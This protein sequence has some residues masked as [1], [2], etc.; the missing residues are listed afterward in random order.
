MMAKA[1]AILVFI[2][3]FLL[4]PRAQA[5]F[6]SKKAKTII[7]E[8]M[9][10]EP[11]TYELH[12]LTAKQSMLERVRTFFSF[13]K[14]TG[15]RTVKRSKL[16]NNAVTLEGVGLAIGYLGLLVGKISGSLPAYI[17]G[18]GLGALFFIAGMVCNIVAMAKHEK[19]VLHGI[20]TIL[21]GR[22]FFIPLFLGVLL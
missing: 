10:A 15:R 9:T 12:D 22:L 6:Y 16:A 20:L 19:K 1:Y 3:I 17:A 4:A 2:L 8:T 14:Y 7:R 13:D 11:G 18:V 5:G 21:F